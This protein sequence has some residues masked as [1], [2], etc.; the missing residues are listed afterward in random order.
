MDFLIAH[1]DKIAASKLD[2][3][4]FDHFSHFAF[5]IIHRYWSKKAAQEAAK[6]HGINQVNKCK[7][8]N[9]LPALQESILDMDSWELDKDAKYFFFCQNES[10]SGL[11]L[12]QT[13]M[14][15]VFDRIKKEMPWQIIVADMSSSIGSRDLTQHD[16]WQDF[17]VIYAG[18]QKNLGTS[19]LTFV[20]VRD[21]VLNRV[22]MIKDRAKLPIPPLMDWSLTASQKDFFYNTPSLFSIYMSHLMCEH[23]LEMGGIEYYEQLADTKAKKLYKLFDQSLEYVQN[24][25]DGPKYGEAF[26]MHRIYFKNPIEE[27]LRSRMNVPFNLA[28]LDSSISTQ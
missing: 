15:R 10:I 3:F 16:L 6:Y 13:H 9:D 28:S 14:R 17:G 27:R 18:A 23:M 22:K 19:G 11:E 1:P 5:V 24:D 7:D 12:D 8:I 2:A 26:D 20:C 25:D 4:T 21:D